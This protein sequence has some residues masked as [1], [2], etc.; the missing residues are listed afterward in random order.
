MSE[1]EQPAFLATLAEMDRRVAEIDREMADPEVASNGQRLQS[2]MRERG[3]LHRYVEPFRRWRELDR[4]RAEAAE[5]AADSADAEMQ[6][7]AKAETADLAEQEERLLDE[8]REL[9]LESEAR[10]DAPS[11]ILEIRAGT[12]GDEAAL[13][14]GDLLE[15]YRRLSERRGWS[16]EILSASPTPLGGYREAVVNIAGEGCYRELAFESGGH[17]VQRVPETESQ[18]RIHTSAATVAVMPEPEDLDVE[19]NAEDLKIETMRSSG[20][21]G[22]NVNKVSSAVRM[23]HEP[24]GITVMMQESKSQHQNREKAMRLMRSRVFDHYE[25]QRRAEREAQ[26]KLKVGTGDRSG[27]IRTYNFPQNRVT[28]HRIGYT[29]H[30]LDAVLQ[31]DLDDLLEALR[32]ADREDRLAAM[33]AEG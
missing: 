6:E 24:T 30:N 16:V 21:G 15:M 26:R 31:G 9:I 25:S 17:R 8:L 12:G 20:P 22:Q 13:F 29:S 18:G 19:L 27:R 32:M 7:L 4:Q 11:L 10:L 28:D 2:L 1:N 14:A 33:S 23:T 5:L 3:R